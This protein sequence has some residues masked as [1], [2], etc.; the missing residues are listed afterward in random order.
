[1]QLPKVTAALT[2]RGATVRQG[3]PLGALGVRDRWAPRARNGGK[4]AYGG[5][6]IWVG[7]G[8]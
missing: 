4:S 3:Q 2:I 5:S 7:G 8:N 6:Q 1:M